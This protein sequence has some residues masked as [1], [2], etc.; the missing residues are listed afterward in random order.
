MIPKPDE[1][2][3]LNKMDYTSLKKVAKEVNEK[4]GTKIKL[5]GKATAIRKAIKDAV[6]ANAPK[7]EAAKPASE[8]KPEPAAEEKPAEQP[9]S[10]PETKP[11]AEPKGTVMY[12]AKVRYKDKES[13]WNFNPELETKPKPIKKMTPGLKH[14]IATGKVVRVFVEE[15]E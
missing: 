8:D 9:K 2:D 1:L 15:E 13:G 7:E 3:T 14:A 4:Y 5:T 6:K 10:E 12:V 11:E